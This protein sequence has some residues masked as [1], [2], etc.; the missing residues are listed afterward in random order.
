MLTGNPPI[1]RGVVALMT[2]LLLV[3]TAVGP[4]VALQQAPDTERTAGEPVALQESPENETGSDDDR[5]EPADEAYITEDGAVLV[6]ENETEDSD[7]VAVEYGGDVATGLVDGIVEIKDEDTENITGTLGLEA[8]EDS[9]SGDANLSFQNVQDL[10][11][12]T[13]T[14][15]GEH[16][17]NDSYFTSEFEGQIETGK[18][19]RRRRAI[20]GETHGTFVT[21][22]DQ[23]RFTAN[24]SVGDSP[25]SEDAVRQMDY[26]VEE[27]AETNGFTVTVAEKKDVR[28]APE[29]W[30]SKANA[31]ETLNQ[32]YMQTADQYGGS[33]DVT[34]EAYQY[35][36]ASS[37][38]PGTVTIEYTVELEN[39]REGMNEQLVQSLAS[40]QRMNLTDEETATLQ[41]SLDSLELTRVEISYVQG[42]RG[43]ISASTTVVLTDYQDPVLTYMDT[44]AEQDDSISAED[45]NTTRK[46]FEAQEAADLRQELTWSASASPGE[47]EGITVVEASAEYQT[48]NWEEYLQERHDGDLSNQTE[49]TF[50]IEAT[51]EGEKVD[52]E[53]TFQ[54][55]REDVIDDAVERAVA[56]SKNHPD[57][58]DE[59]EMQFLKAFNESDV[60]VAKTDIVF[61]EDTV[62]VRAAG[63]FENLSAFQQTQDDIPA[64]TGVN[65]VYG[66]S[67]ATTNTTETYV[68]VENGNLTADSIKDTKL[69]D[70]DTEVHAQGEWDR[71][72][73]RLNTTDTANYL[74]VETEPEDKDS[75]SGIPVI[76]IA[77][78]L[79]L[80]ISG[81]GA[82]YWIKG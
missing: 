17:A 6:Y 51:S 43:N 31:T 32:Q 14:A 8:R 81:G 33:A 36:K 78:L 72:F 63:Q 19:D 75:G 4:A 5:I 66:E 16:T 64:N 10:D 9:V 57:D 80:V 77:V 27:N 60:H 34:V 69:A 65:H 54:V 45:V 38:E 18:D 70:S 11:N 50:N 47:K 29:R 42:T 59:E 79:V 39:V 21:T 53:M 52:V 44:V 26:L 1:A 55:N 56:E 23:L 7:A 62:E 68:Y 12:F 37:S 76:P 20:T 28:F 15:E 30:N 2:M 74:D 35:E 61:G 48:E 3:S 67:N 40:D 82:A 25:S 58:V 46:T 13:F 73:P 24:A 41:E 49:A 71:E 22:A